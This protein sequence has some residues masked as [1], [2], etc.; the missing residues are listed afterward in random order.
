MRNDGAVITAASAVGTAKTRATNRYAGGAR[1]TIKRFHGM[2]LIGDVLSIG[3][4]NMRMHVTSIP[5]DITTTSPSSGS[6]AALTLQ[7]LNTFS[8]HVVNEAGMYHVFHTVT[9]GAFQP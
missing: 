6:G 2:F 8:S 3:V 1:N 9:V 7:T 5:G 4:S